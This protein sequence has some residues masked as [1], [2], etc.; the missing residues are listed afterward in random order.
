[1]RIIAVCN[2]KGGVGKTTTA[3][4][5]AACFAALEKRTLLIDMDPQANAS[6]SFGFNEDQEE[7]IVEALA[8]A[9]DPDHVT[10]A[11]LT[12]MIQ[13]TGLAYLDILPASPGLAKL[14]IDLV[15][16]MGR[17]RRLERLLQALDGS[18]EFVFNDSPPSLNMLTINT[19]TAA[20][21]VVVPV[22]CEY[23]ALQGVAEL[24]NTIQLVQK[25]LNK[26]LVV[27]G[28]ILTMSDNRLTLSKQV[29]EEVRAHFPGKVF[30]T[31]VPRNVKLSEAPSHS[32]PI[33][34]YDIQSIGAK[35][36]M[37]LAAEL[38]GAPIDSVLDSIL[39]K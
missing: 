26:N 19:L 29:A 24:F 28:A 15:N 9:A 27:E 11:A 31:M 17:E 30:E 22:Q 5:L 1:M 3:V 8:L 6:Q 33:I 16:Q 14:E 34:L 32:K 25:N 37:K 18:Y 12:P 7:D 13:K 4:N 39:K 23:F 21:G 35:S 10:Q 36:Y 20:T 38:M 2:Q